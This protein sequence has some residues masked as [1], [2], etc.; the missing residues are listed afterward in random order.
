MEPTAILW[1]MLAMMTLTLTV[2]GALGLARN[3]ALKRG[4]V[5]LRVFRTFSESGETERLLAM[6]RNLANLYEL[7]TIFIALCL[8]V[9]VAGLV[10]EVLVGL[11][12]AFVASRVVHSAIHVTTNNVLH[13]FLVFV[14]GVTMVLVMLVVVAVR[15]AG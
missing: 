2:T 11:A 13:R 3:I 5:S 14:S 6:R 10:N 9:F 12:W 1:P 4:T 7:P 15:L 8:T